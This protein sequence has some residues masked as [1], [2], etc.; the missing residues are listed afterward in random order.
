MHYALFAQKT[1]A[2]RKAGRLVDPRVR[3]ERVKAL[4]ARNL[5]RRAIA[6]ELQVSERTVAYDAAKI[7]R[8]AAE[9][10]SR[11]SVLEIAAD[12][13]QRCNARQRELWRLFLLA[14]QVDARATAIVLK[15]GILKQ[16]ARESER[17][18]GILLKLGIVSPATE[19]E[20]ASLKA[21]TLL[22]SIPAGE[23]ELA[24]GCDTEEFLDVLRRN[25]GDEAMRMFAVR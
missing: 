20:S 22:N 18:I 2:V 24:L 8:E 25:L 11:A 7:R 23:L 13:I 5:S 15:L 9:N 10:I 12:V 6:K 16:L 19:G 3:R 17:E 14:D 1:A 21:I 4:I